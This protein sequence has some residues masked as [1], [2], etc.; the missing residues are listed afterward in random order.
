MIAFSKGSFGNVILV[1]D[2]RLRHIRQLPM[3]RNHQQKGISNLLAALEFQSVFL[4]VLRGVQIQCF[5]YANSSKI[6]L[7]NPYAILSLQLHYIAE[8]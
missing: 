2:P 6:A 1:Q 3:L 5:S 8:A 7:C 4:N